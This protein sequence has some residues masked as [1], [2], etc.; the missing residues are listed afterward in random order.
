MYFLICASLCSCESFYSRIDL[1]I[2]YFKRFSYNFPS[3]SLIISP[4]SPLPSKRIK[5]SSIKVPPIWISDVWA[6]E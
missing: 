4:H 1:E 3:T 6:E 2:N 5:M